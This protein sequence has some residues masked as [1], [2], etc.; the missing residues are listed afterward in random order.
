MEDGGEVGEGEVGKKHVC[1]MCGK[2]FN[3]PSS[4]R[5]HANTHTG[6]TRESSSI[7]ISLCTSVAADDSTKH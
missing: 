4:L 3:R 7:L 2:G 6:A 5:I 1:P